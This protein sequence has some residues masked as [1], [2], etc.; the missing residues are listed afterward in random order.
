M[1]KFHILM[2]H[3]NI[4]SFLHTLAVVCKLLQITLRKCVSWVANL[5]THI[6]PSIYI[7]GINS[8][9]PSTQGLWSITGTILQAWPELIDEK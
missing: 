5:G 3:H 2:D 1:T 4:I 6:R 7:K 9:G 8:A